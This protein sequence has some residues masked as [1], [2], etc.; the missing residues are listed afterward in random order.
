MQLITVHVELRTMPEVHGVTS[1]LVAN[2]D[3]PGKIIAK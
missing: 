2:I 1:F 3:N